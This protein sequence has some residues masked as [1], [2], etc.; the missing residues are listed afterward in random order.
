LARNPSRLTTSIFF[1]TEPLQPYSPYVTNAWREDGSTV[2]N[3]CWPS[4]AQSFSGPSPARLIA[5]LLSQIETP[6]AWRARSPCLYPSVTGWPSYAP[7]HWVPFSSPPTTRRAPVEV[8]E[9]AS[10]RADEL[11]NLSLAYNIS[12]RS[13]VAV[14]LNLTKLLQ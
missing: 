12:A 3:C 11:L 10:T 7:R 1:P 6:P 9:P 8:F 2:Y 4:P 5:F 13:S 14:P